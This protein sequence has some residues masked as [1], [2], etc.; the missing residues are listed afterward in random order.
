MRKLAP[1]WNGPVEFNPVVPLAT[2]ELELEPVASALEFC[3]MGSAEVVSAEGVGFK[4]EIVEAAN[5][6]TEIVVVR[7]DC[8]L[9]VVT[10]TMVVRRVT[11]GSLSADVDDPTAFFVAD[12]AGTEAVDTEDPYAWDGV[13][14]GGVDDGDG[15]TEGTDVPAVELDTTTVADLPI[16][17]LK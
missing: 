4:A 11:G 2:A 1:V 16:A 6:V 5:C 17:E 8:P 14:G 3:D 9:D 10:V 12:V 7:A 13:A 15:P